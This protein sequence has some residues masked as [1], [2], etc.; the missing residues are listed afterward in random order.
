M[1]YPGT[2]PD[3]LTTNR[4][5]LHAVRPGHEIRIL[6]AVKAS[7]TELRAY[8]ASLPWAV[9]EPTLSSTS[10]FCKISQ[11]GFARR[12]DFTFLI[13]DRFTSYLHGC[14]G[15]HRL[16][17]VA[18]KAELGYWCRTS[19]TGRGIMTEA[20]HALCRFAFTRLSMKTLEII[21]DESNEKSRRLA[22]RCGFRLTETR[23]QPVAGM[24]RRACVYNMCHSGP[25]A[26][27]Q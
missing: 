14:A 11:D 15:I 12:Q 25:V 2:F 26:A 13:T 24:W 21:T 17:E 7:L 27:A 20:V 22:E 1:T 18:R 5:V 16:D 4:L 8:P 3:V 6:E 23:E 10:A 9:H 19:S